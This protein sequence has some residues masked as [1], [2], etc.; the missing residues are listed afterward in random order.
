MNKQAITTGILVLVIIGLVSAVVIGSKQNKSTQVTANDSSII[1]NVPSSDNK[2]VDILYWGTTCPHCHE[3]IEWIEDNKIDEKLTVLR[4]EVYD[5]QLNSLEL[6][7]KAKK[8]KIEPDYIGV[9]LLYTTDGKCLI[10]T[11]DIT[12]YLSEKT[13]GLK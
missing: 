1:E 13:G 2:D 6:V 9:P 7:E 10:G 12:K 11:P 5:N 4:K 3:T 8:C